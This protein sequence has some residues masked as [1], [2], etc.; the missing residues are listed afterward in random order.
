MK[1]FLATLMLVVSS[2]SMADTPQL[3]TEF[4]Q[5]VQAI[6]TENASK[7]EVVELFWYGCPHCHALE[8]QLAAW[9]KALPKDVTFKR[10]P[11]LPRPD[12][13]PGAKAFYVMESLGLLDKLHTKFFDALHKQRAF[14]PNDEKAIIDWITKESGL[15]RKKV[16]AEFNSF[17]LN[18]KLNHAAQ[19]F[20]ASGATGVPTLIIDGRY[21][22]SVTMAGG[23]QEVFNVANY[24]IDN[25]RKDK[26]GRK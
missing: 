16:E 8:P 12:W 17:S 1:K 11:G 9:V 23:N 18:T 14:L 6:P 10:V 24:I 22:T 20:R 25:I 13:A 19:I 3:G 15:D 5:T 26:A 4:N 2:I 21:I 7:I